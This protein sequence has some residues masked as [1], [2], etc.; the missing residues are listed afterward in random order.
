M[1]NQVC[2]AWLTMEGAQEHDAQFWFSLYGLQQA[3]VTE[4]ENRW[5]Q[6]LK[7]ILS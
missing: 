6:E 4:L 3:Q 7:R 1:A 2:L 5:A